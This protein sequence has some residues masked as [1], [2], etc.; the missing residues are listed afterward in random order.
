MQYSV[1][2]FP[3]P[4]ETHPIASFKIFLDQNW[5]VAINSCIFSS[6]SVFLCHLSSVCCSN[7]TN[8]HLGYSMQTQLTRHRIGPGNM[9]IPHNYPTFQHTIGNTMHT[10]K[11]THVRICMAADTDNESLFE[12]AM[13]KHQEITLS[14]CTI[15]STLFWASVC[16]VD[17]TTWCIG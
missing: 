14:P 4:L 13:L 15:T 5:Q 8:S 3:P 10:N 17:I 16:L 9:S 12:L 1:L 2:V 6:L 11:P 7:Y